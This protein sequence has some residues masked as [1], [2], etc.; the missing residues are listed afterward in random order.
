MPG[1]AVM[2]DLGK[3]VK[4]FKTGKISGRQLWKR[5]AQYD[6]YS[7]VEAFQEKYPTATSF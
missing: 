6:D 1:A 7:V 4:Q 2:K 3:S 5:M